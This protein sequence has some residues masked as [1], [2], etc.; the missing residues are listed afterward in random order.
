M[1]NAE[2]SNQSTA[3][4]RPGVHEDADIA[5]GVYD[6]EIAILELEGTNGTSPFSESAAFREL[7]S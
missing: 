1:T 4:P 5:E 3:P 6:S 7:E 2:A